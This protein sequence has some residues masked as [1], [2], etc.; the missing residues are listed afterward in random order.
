[1]G[2][3]HRSRE[4]ALQCLY[5]WEV[6]C[7]AVDELLANFWKLQPEATSDV[8][9]FTETLVYGT[10]AA[11]DEIDDAIRRQAENWRLD[12]MGKV[13]LSVLRLGTFELLH[14]PQTP[15]AVVI[16]EA[17]ELAKR[18]G[19]VQAGQFV[20]GVLDGIRRRAETRPLTPGVV[21]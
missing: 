5:C 4:L 18:F 7:C 9:E 3:R 14:C 19:D 17:I 13:D 1:M 12:R 6:T 10:V 2:R 16:D 8:R 21:S 20:N 11:V 15:I